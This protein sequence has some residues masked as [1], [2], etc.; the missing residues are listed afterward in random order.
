VDALFTAWAPSVFGIGLPALG[1]AGYALGVMSARRRGIAWPGWRVLIWMVTAAIA[2]WTL[3]GP[4][5]ALRHVNPWMDGVSIG[6]AAAVLPLGVALGDPVKLI[7]LLRGRRIGWMRGRIARFFM[8]P[9]VASL[10]SAIVLTFAITSA[11]YQAALTEPLPWALLLLAAFVT[12]LSVNLPLLSDDLMPEW[13]TPAVKTLIAFADGLFDAI[14][15]LVMML[16]VNKYSGGALL[17]IAEVV[18]IPM[19]A[20]TVV[21]WVRADAEE[22]RAV[23]AELDAREAAAASRP[24]APATRAET[25]SDQPAEPAEASGLWWLDDPRFADR[26][27]D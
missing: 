4:P 20:A 12:G 26:F 6:I 10:L 25:Q 2:V 3:A 27:R 22:Q 21:M 24:A 18:G 11:W 14:P 15:G 1:A 17:A 7:E 5:A 19:I 8:F 16:L 9:G 23:D 13:A